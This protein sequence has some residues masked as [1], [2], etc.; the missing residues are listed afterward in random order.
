[1]REA[2]KRALRW[3]SMRLMW[4]KRCTPGLE[5]IG[6][7]SIKCVVASTR[8]VSAPRRAKNTGTTRRSGI[9]SKTRHTKEK[10]PLAKL[11]GCQSSHAYGHHEGG[12]PNPGVDTLEMMLQH[13]SGLLFPCLPSLTL[14][15]SMLYRSSW[16]RIGDELAS[17]RKALAPSCKVCLYVLNVDRRI[18]VEPMMSAMRSIV[19][20]AQ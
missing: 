15:Y 18:V 20:E 2:E 9:G 14:P 19:V 3:C 8:Q 11:A 5:R 1:M 12:R 4:S 17:Q 10:Q 6:A 13:T 16:K 7:R